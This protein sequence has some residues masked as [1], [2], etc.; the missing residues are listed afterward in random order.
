[1]VHWQS[2]LFFFGALVTFVIL[3]TYLGKRLI[4]PLGL[5]PRWRRLAWAGIVVLGASG[6]AVMAAGRMLGQSAWFGPLP[7]I[8]FGLMGAAGV[9]FS[10]VVFRDLGWL[11]VKGVMWGV[12][13]WRA[14]S[15][16]AVPPAPDLARRRFLFN[17]SSLGVVVGASAGTGVGVWT[18]RKKRVVREEVIRVPGL[19]EAFDGFR[20]VQL[21]DIHVG[22]T[23][24]K[25]DLVAMVA[26][27]NALSP[28]MVAITGDLVDGLVEDMGEDISPLADLQATHGAFY[29]TGNHEYYWDGP[30]WCA[31]VARQGVVVLNNAHRVIEREGAK[32]VVAGVTD[33]TAHRIEPSHKSDPDA[34]VAGA[35]EDAFRVF[36]AHQPRSVAGALA[37]QADLVLVG[38]THGGQFF[39]LNLFTDVI[40]G[41]GHGL[42]EAPQGR[43]V[44]VS[45]GAGYWGPPMR[46]GVPAEVNL[47]VLRRA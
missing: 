43:W 22:P 42:Y 33:H 46:L 27:A 25:A 3:G 6:P 26:E 35:P 14:R 30:G 40:H 32:L 5:R 18:A 38:H 12:A 11:V 24:C 15:S 28:D 44:Y 21:S 41:Y 17:V 7:W 10:F 1:V 19:P 31:Q 4:G 39:P 23:I 2:I 29:C 45:A 9:L 47:V 16:A 36:L 20:I 34:A 13:R 37:A 8:G